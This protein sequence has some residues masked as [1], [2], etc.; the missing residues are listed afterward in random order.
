MNT[1]MPNLLN[2]IR[3]LLGVQFIFIGISMAFLIADLFR[4]SADYSA[5]PLS[6][7]IAYFVSI[8][9]RVL[10][11]LVPPILTI[12]FISRR[13]YTLTI[14]FMSLALFFGVVFFQ[15]FL[16]LLHIFMLLTLLLHKPSKVYLKQESSREE[17]NQNNL[18]L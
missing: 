2:V 4:D 14:T 13:S 7:Q 9:L 16:V 5:F 17:Y 18:R 15:N 6:D 12:V 8:G 10:M 1:K 11:V 3:A